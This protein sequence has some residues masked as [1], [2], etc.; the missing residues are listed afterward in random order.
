MIYLL[1][2]V[3]DTL[4]YPKFDDYNFLYFDSEEDAVRYA[5]ENLD[6]YSFIWYITKVEKCK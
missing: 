1:A 3:T 4:V 5:G 2:Y 6:K